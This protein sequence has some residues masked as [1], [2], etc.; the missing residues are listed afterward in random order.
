MNARAGPLSRIHPRSGFVIKVDIGTTPRATT[1][2]FLAHSRHFHMDTREQVRVLQ[3]DAQRDAVSAHATALDSGAGAAGDTP[4]L[5]IEAQ[6]PDGDSIEALERAGAFYFT[7]PD[8]ATT[9]GQAKEAAGSGGNPRRARA[10]YRCHRREVHKALKDLMREFRDHKRQKRQV[11]GPG[12]EPDGGVLPIVITLSTAGGFGPV[13]GDLKRDIAEVAAELGVNVHLFVFILAQG[14]LLPPNPA[15]AARNEEAF[16]A[17]LQADLVA[18]IDYAG[19]RTEIASRHLPQTVLVLTNQNVYG[20]IASL[21]RFENLVGLLA[22]HLVHTQ[23]GQLF[24]ERAIALESA[25]DSPQQG[26]PRSVSTAGVSVLHLHKEKLL[27]FAAYETLGGLCEALLAPADPGP[28]HQMATALVRSG[29]LL[30]SAEEPIASTRAARLEAYGGVDVF[31]R[32]RSVF[33][34]RLQDLQGFALL[35]N[36]PRAYRAALAVELVKNLVPAIDGGCAQLLENALKAVRQDIGQ[37]MGDLNG[38]RRT[39]T[40]LSA[41]RTLLRDSAQA[42]AATAR[43]LAESAR[44]VQETLG[45]IEEEVDAMARRSGLWRVFQSGRIRELARTYRPAAEADLRCQAELA[46]RGAL[47]RALYRLLLTAV[48]EELAR[49][50]GRLASF[51]AL[52]QRAEN[53]RAR[54]ARRCNSTIAQTW[55]LTCGRVAST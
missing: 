39:Q 55:R 23:L 13:Y 40:Y 12:H 18:N 1:E 32:V 31:D 6:V 24:Q 2:R 36:L 37:F 5:F 30:E 38:L 51:E 43:A 35:Q 11:L 26:G 16:L 7:R 9:D 3:I 22:F 44:P 8:W 17:Y 53:G 50:E 47:E 10:L 4:I 21:A 49:A 54:T 41:L 19:P 33:E 46:V 34:A 27:G 20:E 14:T 45:A 25:N 28:I 48:G 42:N 29:S 52:R 15:Q